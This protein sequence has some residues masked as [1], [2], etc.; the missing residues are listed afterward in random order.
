MIDSKIIF[1]PI[2]ISFMRQLVIRKNTC[3]AHEIHTHLTINT[4]INEF[5]R[6]SSNGQYLTNNIPG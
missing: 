6:M 2:N 1:R 4:T 5:W 3:R